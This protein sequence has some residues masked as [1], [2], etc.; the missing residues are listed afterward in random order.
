MHDKIKEL[1][2]DTKH[3]VFIKCTFP[4]NL[5]RLQYVKLSEELERK[6][7]QNIK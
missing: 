2:N 6:I 5:C 4:L 7:L 1:C 3:N